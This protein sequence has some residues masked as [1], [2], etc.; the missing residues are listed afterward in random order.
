MYSGGG[1]LE[2]SCTY[3]TCAGDSSCPTGQTCACAGSPY[4][5]G[6]DNTCVQGNCRVDA[7]CEGGSGYCSPALNAN[8]C[9]SI[10]GYYC[11][12]PNDQCVNDTDC[13][14]TTMGPQVCT[15][16]PTDGRWECAAE[17]FCG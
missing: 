9:G 16:A 4:T 5:G 7:D 1:A 2:C 10:L 14:D 11:H 8:S 13:Q 12:T 6:S 3:A 15:Y 17:G